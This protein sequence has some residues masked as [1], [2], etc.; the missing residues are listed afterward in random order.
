MKLW[1]KMMKGIHPDEEDQFNDIFEED[2]TYGDPSGGSMGDLGDFMV[3]GGYSPSPYGAPVQNPNP[4]QGGF[5]QPGQPQPVYPPQQ[6]PAAQPAAG[7]MTVSV[8]GNTQTSVELKVVKPGDY[9][10][11]TQIADHLINR[12]TVILNL[13]DTNK[14]TSRRLL[15]FLA[16]VAYTI[17]GQIERVA[18]RTFVITPS[19]IGISADHLKDDSRAKGGSTRTDNAIIY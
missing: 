5:S 18:D 15:D 17:Q 12:R 19:N 14:E 11:V 2:E 4:N 6:Q 8:G 16:G 7:G 3:S 1:D 10:E 13:E 9:Q